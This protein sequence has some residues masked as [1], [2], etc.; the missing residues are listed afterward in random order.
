MTYVA[1]AS[2]VTYF[3]LGL[4]DQHGEAGRGLLKLLHRADQP[5]SQQ[6]GHV[7]ERV[8]RAA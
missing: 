6:Q 7:F 4:G 3:R 5:P 1:L 8:Y 2:S